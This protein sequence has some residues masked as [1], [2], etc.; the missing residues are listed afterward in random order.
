[1]TPEMVWWEWAL[2]G[3]IVG[4]ILGHMLGKREPR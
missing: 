1:M 4:F 3:L 2:C